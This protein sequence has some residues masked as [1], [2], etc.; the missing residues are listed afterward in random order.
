MNTTTLEASTPWM[1]ERAARAPAIVIVRAKCPLSASSRATG[2]TSSGTRS[3]MSGSTSRSSS[4]VVAWWRM[5]QSSPIAMPWAQRPKMSTGPWASSAAAKAGAIR[6]ASSRWRAME[7]SEATP[8]QKASPGPSFSGLQERLPVSSSRASQTAMEG[9]MIPV[10]AP[11]A[12]SECAG[13]SVIS[14]RAAMPAATS[15]SAAQ[16]SSTQAAATPLR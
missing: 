5:W 2:A 11:A 8:S 13:A 10:M 4:M 7:A 16:P 12:P 1:V 15:R 9:E 3:A 6:S 14:P